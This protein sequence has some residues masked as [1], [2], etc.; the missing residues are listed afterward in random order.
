MINQK[1]TL[2]TEAVFSDDGKHRFLLR[3]E[4]DKTK[5]SALVI[6]LKF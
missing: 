6:M 3:K 5:K 2:K 1:S 4:W